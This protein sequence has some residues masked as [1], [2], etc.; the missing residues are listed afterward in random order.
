M[1]PCLTPTRDYGENTNKCV[2]TA[3]VLFIPVVRWQQLTSIDC[4]NLNFEAADA[5]NSKACPLSPR[6]LVSLNHV[7]SDML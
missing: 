1:K 6:V 4:P 3:V 2:L 7:M 5:A